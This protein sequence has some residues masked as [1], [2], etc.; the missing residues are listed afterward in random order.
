[1][2]KIM[3]IV[4]VVLIY[5]IGTAP[6]CLS[7]SK[8]GSRG[9]EVTAIQQAL[10]TRG[11]Y[12]GSID[13]I[14]GTETQNA[15]RQFQAENSLVADGIAGDLTLADTNEEA[16]NLLALQTR[17]SLAQSS[18]SLANQAEQSVLNLIR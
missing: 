6:V 12:T 11:Y 9:S 1:M 5:I 2:K 15:L 7:L 8:I 3:K 4:C 13:G 16:A 10:T 17:Q 14:F 18:L